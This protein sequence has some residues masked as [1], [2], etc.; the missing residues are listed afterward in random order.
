MQRQRKLEN[1]LKRLLKQ[2]VQRGEID[3]SKYKNK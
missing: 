3:L 1:E 2:I